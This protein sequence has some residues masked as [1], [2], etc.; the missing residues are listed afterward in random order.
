MTYDA[1]G[2]TLKSRFSTQWATLQ[3]GVEWF[4]PNSGPDPSFNDPWVGLD[5][6]DGASTQINVSPPQYRR[7]G[8][9]TV[10][11]YVPV[12]TGDDVVRGLIDSSRA[13]FENQQLDDGSGKFITLYGAEVVHVGASER[14]SQTN[15]QHEFHYDDL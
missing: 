2:D 1:V 3:P 8:F 6:L 14:F 7:A 15:V 4:A 10:S 12:N 5:I 11:I 9:V 13:V